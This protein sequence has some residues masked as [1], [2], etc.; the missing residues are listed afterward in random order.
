MATPE[1]YPTKVRGTGHG[2]CSSLAR[3]GA[4]LS[5]Y[6]VY[7]SISTP[8]IGLVLAFVSFTA[9]IAAYMLPETTGVKL[10][11][12]GDGDS[13]RVLNSSNVTHIDRMSLRE[14]EGGIGGAIG[15]ENG[16]ISSASTMRYHL[17]PLGQ[18]HHQ[19][20]PHTNIGLVS[21]PMEESPITPNSPIESERGSSE[22]SVNTSGRD[23]TTMS[24]FL[25][26]HPSTID[27]VGSGLMSNTT[28]SFVIEPWDAFP[29]KIPPSYTDNAVNDVNSFPVPYPVEESNTNYGNESPAAFSS[30]MYT[31]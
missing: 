7:S 2:I 5:S 27:N 25:K 29:V 3:L 22:G 28:T 23:S 10:D 16:V 9:A 13:S 20:P 31:L 8:I 6:F 1:L 4:F 14:G 15:V 21:L 30:S 19:Y 18:H 11:S 24:P 26:N 12:E 17:V